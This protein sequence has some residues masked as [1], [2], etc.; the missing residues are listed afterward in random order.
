MSAKK[1][2]NQIKPQSLL[3][4]Q[5]YSAR[6]LFSMAVWGKWFLTDVLRG[7]PWTGD[8]ISTG[9]LAINFSY[10]PFLVLSSNAKFPGGAAEWFP[11]DV[12][13]YFSGLP[14]LGL[15]ETLRP[16]RWSGWQ[17]AARSQHCCDW[18]TKWAPAG[19]H[20]VT[21][22]MVAGMAEEIIPQNRKLERSFKER[23]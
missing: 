1:N 14:C 16:G 11:T 19:W 22:I 2:K 20:Q 8:S 10:S 17:M 7:V 4:R 18:D 6:S 9:C 23:S 12:G 15:A 21:S 5:L 13:E 3:W